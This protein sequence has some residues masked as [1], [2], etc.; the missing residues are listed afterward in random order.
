[1]FSGEWIDRITGLENVTLET[2]MAR[3]PDGRPSSGGRRTKS[4]GMKS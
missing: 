2:V 3:G 1:M 4:S